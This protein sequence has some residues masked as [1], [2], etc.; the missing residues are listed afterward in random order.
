MKLNI[1]LIHYPTSPG[2]VEYMVINMAK[3]LSELDHSTTIVSSRPMDRTLIENLYAITMEG[4]NNEVLPPPYHLRLAEILSAGRL[5]RLRRAAYVR[6]ALEALRKLGEYDLIIDTQSN[7]LTPADISYIHYPAITPTYGEGLQYKIYNAIV[8]LYIGRFTSSPLLVLTNSTWTQEIL[9]RIYKVKSIV[10]HPPIHADLYADIAKIKERE[11]RVITISRLTPEK[12]LD[13]ILEVARYQK[14][15]TFTIAGA[16][17]KHSEA[18]VERL[19][20]KAKLM[21]V[22]NVE[23]VENPTREE[24]KDLLARST[25]YLHPKFPEHYGIAVMEAIAAGCIP[26]VYA[27]GGLWTDVVSRISEDLGYRTLNDVILVMRKLKENVQE[28]ERVRQKSFE[29]IHR[30]DYGHFKYRMNVIIRRVYEMKNVED[31]IKRTY[32]HH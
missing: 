14:N 31:D 3:A 26:I 5:V 18:Y 13:F 2:G 25:Y 1:A 17:T 23:I 11:E 20:K 30:L 28:R 12:N 21:G 10:L 6:Y 32:K 8:K 27:S 24:I 9:R 7:T 29:I 4:V 22:E 16:T 19:K 15:L